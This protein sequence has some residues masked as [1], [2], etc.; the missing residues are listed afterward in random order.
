MRWVLVCSLFGALVVTAFDFKAFECSA[1]VPGSELCLGNWL[2]LAAACYAVQ[3]GCQTS[4]FDLSGLSA[5]VVA[6]CSCC[7]TIYSSLLSATVASIVSD[8]RP[9]GCVPRVLAD[10][11]VFQLWHKVFSVKR[12]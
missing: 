12:H 4:S 7:E 8:G 1:V 6:R 3:C 10:P 2:G 11:T 9:L 5:A